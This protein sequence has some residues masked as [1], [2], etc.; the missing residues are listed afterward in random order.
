M[1]KLCICSYIQTRLLLGLTATQIVVE[2]T[3]AY[4]QGVVS[5]HTVAHWIHQFSSG[6]ESLDDDSRN[7]R[8]IAV[9]TQENIDAIID[10]VKD[11]PH[12]GVGYITAILDIVYHTNYRYKY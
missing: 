11:N 8:P 5:Y 1:D 6:R 7:Y 10:L 12:I 4:G 9:T 3:T 2:L